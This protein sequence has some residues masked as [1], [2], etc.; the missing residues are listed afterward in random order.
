MKN[1]DTFSTI[2]EEKAAHTGVCYVCARTYYRG[3]SIMIVEISRDILGNRTNVA[4]HS[5][6]HD[7]QANAVGKEEIPNG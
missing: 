4:V 7:K 6:C 5:V 1:N 3:D 2:T